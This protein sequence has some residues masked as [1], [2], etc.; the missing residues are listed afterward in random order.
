M[1]ARVKFA[2]ILSAGLLFGMT[3]GL[4]IL[5]A[6]PELISNGVGFSSS[7][8]PYLQSGAP[9][10]GKPAPNFEAVD[11]AGNV[12][13]LDQFRGKNVLLNFWASW[14]GPCRVEMPLLEN[15]QAAGNQDLEILGIN[16]GESVNTVQR[17]ADEVGLSFRLLLDPH[18][19]IRAEYLIIGLPVSIFIDKEGLVAAEHIGAMT[20]KQMMGYLTLLGVEN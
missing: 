14:C 4:I 19:D 5:R 2:V 6:D 10:V 13:T 3:I 8:A 16:G 18:G 20:E 9:V 7:A 1:A 11:L 12:V 17:F 15:L